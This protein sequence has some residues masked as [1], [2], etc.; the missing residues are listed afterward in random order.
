MSW[1]R[2]FLVAA[3][4]AAL[5]SGCGFHPLYGQR[6]S[7][8]PAGIADQMAA[9]RISGIQDREGQMLRNAL[10]DRLTPR[11]EP[12][13]PAYILDVRLSES[14]TGLGQQKNSYASLGEM[15]VAASFSLLSRDGRNGFSSAA[16]SVVSVNFLGP[17]YASVAV[18]RDATERAIADVADSIRD[19]VAAWL[20]DPANKPSPQAVNPELPPNLQ[21]R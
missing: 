13:T 18:E 6:S 14:M 11:G 1:S 16:H 15:N 3:G 7:A 5:S 17:R 2:S 12:S 8:A 4:V 9:I 19:Q 10:I 21:R 20:G